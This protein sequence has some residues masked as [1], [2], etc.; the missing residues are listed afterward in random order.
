[1]KRC[2]TVK[3]LITAIKK[4]ERATLKVWGIMHNSFDANGAYLNL[5]EGRYAYVGAESWK[6]IRNHLTNENGDYCKNLSQ[7]RYFYSRSAA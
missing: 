7:Y 5:G 2:R 6:L 4:G 1:M 3:G